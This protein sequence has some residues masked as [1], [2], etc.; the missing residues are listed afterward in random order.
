MAEFVLSQQ[1]LLAQYAQLAPL[2]DLISY[3]Y[4]TNPV[5]GTVLRDRVSSCRFSIHALADLA[6]VPSEK[7]TFFAQ[8]W[9]ALYVQDLLERGIRWFVVDNSADLL[10]LLHVLE[11]TPFPITLFLRLRIKEHTIHT[12]KYFVFGFL[13]A[14]IHRLVGELSSHPCIAALGIHFHR[15]TQ[16]I[17]EWY[18]QEELAQTLTPATLAL[19]DYINIGGGIPVTYKN[20]HAYHLTS[21]FFQISSLRLWLSSFQIQLI[22]EPGRFLAAPCVRLHTQI[23]SI[24]D[25]NIIVDCSVYNAAMDTFVAHV[26]LPVLEEQDSGVAYTIKG[27]TPDSMDIFRYQVFLIHPHVGDTL[28]FLHAGAYTYSTNFCHLPQIPVRIVD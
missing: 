23:L 4:K 22:L 27:I 18:L 9:Q 16:N 12:G 21:I 3:S 20:S 11:I 10:V 6:D 5:V 25:N 19:L 17:S 7:V 28:T 13:S 15:K 2:T 1:T 8:G 26:R 14:D 24:Y